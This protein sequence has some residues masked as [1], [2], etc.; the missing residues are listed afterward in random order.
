MSGAP[1]FSILL[2]THNRPEV[3]RHAIASVLA[4]D[5]TDFELLVVGDGCTDGTA[6]LVQGFD[7]PRIRWFDRPKGPGFG[8]ANRNHALAEARGEVIGFLGHD[9]LL[10]ADHLDLFDRAFRDP[11]LHFVHSLPLWIRDDG[12]I[13][14]SFANLRI[15]PVRRNF[16]KHYNVLPATCVMHR[17]SCFDAVGMWPTDLERGGDYELWKRILDHYPHRAVG[18]LRQPTC[19]HFRADWRDPQRWAP[20]PVAYLG[21]IHDAGRFWPPALALPLEGAETPQAGA[22]RILR[23]GGPGWLAELRGAVALL[24]DMLAHHA[25]LDGNFAL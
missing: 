9:N 17:R 20:P 13:A 19:L 18:Y 2:P 6:D 1:R 23:D 21:A 16:M 5:F 11:Q 3:L 24:R 4:Q 12:L 22:W 8:Y 25:G 14:P 7:D 15:P 10:F